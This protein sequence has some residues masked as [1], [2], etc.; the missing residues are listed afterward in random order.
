MSM[1]TLPRERN[2]RVINS[3][4]KAWGRRELTGPVTGA[5]WVSGEGR[6]RSEAEWDLARQRLDSHGEELA[7]FGYSTSQFVFIQD[8]SGSAGSVRMPLW[9]P[10]RDRMALWSE[11]GWCE[12]QA[13][14]F[15]IPGLI[16]P[17]EKQIQIVIFWRSHSS[18][19]IAD[20]MQLQIWLFSK[21]MFFLAILDLFFE[22]TSFFYYMSMFISF[23]LYI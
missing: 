12:I 15:Y 3:K 8:R 19:V 20:T 21:S 13:F 14:N 22:L 9:L 6:R 7:L 11:V 16:L 2:I 17:I 10:R 1:L 5:S 23:Y 18:Y 4:C